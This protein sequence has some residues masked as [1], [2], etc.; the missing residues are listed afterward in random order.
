MKNKTLMVIAVGLILATSL[1]AGA[2]TPVVSINDSSPRASVTF[3]SPAGEGGFD[4]IH[5]NAPYMQINAIVVWG[6]PYTGGPDHAQWVANQELKIDWKLYIWSWTDHQWLLWQTLPNSNSTDS[7]YS[8]RDGS[9]RSYKY[10]GPRRFG[11]T[12]GYFYAL[13]MRVGWV[14]AGGG[15]AM[16]AAYYWFDQPGDLR[17][18]GSAYNCRVYPGITTTG[19]GDPNYGGPNPQRGVQALYIHY[20]NY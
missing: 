18:I 12:P 13:S 4:A 14:P 7:V 6:A 10:F 20:Y 8:S 17:C 15:G 2:V 19:L 3:S 11:V 1:P 9:Y 16:A 5:N